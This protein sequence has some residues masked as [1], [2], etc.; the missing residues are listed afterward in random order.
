MMIDSANLDIVHHLLMYECDPTAV[1]DDSNLPDGICDNIYMDVAA[2][3]SN[4]AIGWAVGGD[5]VSFRSYHLLVKD[6][7]LDRLWNIQKL[8]DIQLE[9]TLQSNTTWYK[10]IIIIQI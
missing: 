5:F 8:L 3:A 9:V 10:Y 6:L 7:F 1:F 4:I 2:C